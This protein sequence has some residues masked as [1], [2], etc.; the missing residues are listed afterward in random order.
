M[1]T[2]NSE[3]YNQAVASPAAFTGGS[4]NTR[5]D[6]GGTSDPLTLFTVTGIVA[7]KLIGYSTVLPVSA[8]GGTLSVGTAISTTGLL[9]STTASSIAV[10]EIWHDNSPDASVELSS[11]MTEKIVSQNIIETV[12]TADITA[13]NVHYLCLWRPLTPNATVVPANNAVV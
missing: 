8:G 6:D 5:G 4:A 12:G 2:R 3:T 7:V 10:G 11:V 13:G 9:A 1:F